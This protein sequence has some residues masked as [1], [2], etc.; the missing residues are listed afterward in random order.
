MAVP[1]PPQPPLQAVG[2]AFYTRE[3]EENACK[4]CCNFW[5]GHLS[6][7]S[8]DACPKTHWCGLKG[9]G[10]EEKR[11]GGKRKQ[12]LQHKKEQVTRHPEGWN[13]YMKSMCHLTMDVT[14]NAVSLDQLGAKM[15]MK[16]FEPTWQVH[17]TALIVLLGL[18]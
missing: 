11:V 16:N 14:C 15:H 13:I 4:G 12:T 18:R 7:I 3:T 2:L 17:E 8:L 6:R 9:V 10:D 5:Q 1:L